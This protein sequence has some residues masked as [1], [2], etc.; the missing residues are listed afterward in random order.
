MKIQFS[1]V[2][3]LI[4]VGFTTKAQDKSTTDL[5]DTASLL[6]IQQFKAERPLGYFLSRNEGNGT[7][8][9]SGRHLPIMLLIYKRG[10]W[11]HVKRA[12]SDPIKLMNL[13]S[14]EKYKGKRP[15][16]KN[17]VYIGP[18]LFAVAEYR[19]K[20]SRYL[21]L[22]KLNINTGSIVD[23]PKVIVRQKVRGLKYLNK[24]DYSFIPTPDGTKVALIHEQ[25]RK[26][27][28]Q[29]GD[30][31]Y[32]LL[33]EDLQKVGKR[34]LKQKTK[35]ASNKKEK[36]SNKN[37]NGYSILNDGTLYTDVS[38]DFRNEKELSL[39]GPSLLI[40]PIDT[41][42]VVN[43]KL[44]DEINYEEESQ[45]G[46][47][48]W[49]HKDTSYSAL[50]VKYT[51]VDKKKKTYSQKLLLTNNL[52][53]TTDETTWTEL[54]YPI[55]GA[56]DALNI[57][58]YVIT[59]ERIAIVYHY[60]TETEVIVHSSGRK[61]YRTAYRLNKT[62]VIGLSDSGDIA[63]INPISLEFGQTSYSANYNPY[64][65]FRKNDQL[66]FVNYERK[67]LWSVIPIR[68]FYEI[69]RI[70]LKTGE[71]KYEKKQVRYRIPAMKDSG[72]V[73]NEHS[74]S[75]HRTRFWQLFHSK[76]VYE[77]SVR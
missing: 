12:G 31:K 24:F 2:I 34:T 65:I 28:N 66:Y 59:G 42:Y 69:Y 25:T 67:Y 26:T 49:W 3:I 50:G 64:V 16:L 72:D 76:K 7:T 46:S 14:M 43:V 73:L 41:N 30:K 11:F 22:Q 29:K 36:I 5:S 44:N 47:L 21:M 8:I 74:V 17:F 48:S 70:K 39:D 32:I 15:Q 58:T 54:D 51:I 13:K 71:M 4:L 1:L 55:G 9:F 20:G 77:F 38:E 6:D 68:S 23:K 56:D 45:I 27:T 75:A 63:W 60:T 52:S 37:S 33:D 19:R 40:Y 53:L 57:D 62:N 18:E 10:V 61:S 35:S